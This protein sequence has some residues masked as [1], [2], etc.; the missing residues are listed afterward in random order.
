MIRPTASIACGC[1]GKGLPEVDCLQRVAED[2]WRCAKHIRRAPCCIE[3]CGRTFAID[4]DG[5]H[6][7]FMCGTHWRMGPKR[8]R[9]ATAAIRRRAKKAGWDDRL[10]ERHHQMWHRT[11][12]AIER[13][14]AGDVDM[15]VI[16]RLFG[17]DPAA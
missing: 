14:L 11:R 7:V 1:C 15:R 8:M 13:T 17:W 10:R 6:V 2:E 16:E 3:G 9:E 12:R 4:E 5:Y